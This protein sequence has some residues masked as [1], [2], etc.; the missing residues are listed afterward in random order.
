MSLNDE[1]LAEVRDVES[2]VTFDMTDR[3]GPSN[4]LTVEVAW[5]PADSSQSK[6]G[7][8]GA[9]AIEIHDAS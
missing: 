2:T 1:P 9:V 7:L 5:S 6:G 4:I 8:W 3:I